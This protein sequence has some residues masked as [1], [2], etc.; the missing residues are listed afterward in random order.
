MNNAL[1]VVACNAS[2]AA[3]LI[4]MKIKA[5]AVGITTLSTSR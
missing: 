5:Y 3:F 1:V 2:M 4:C